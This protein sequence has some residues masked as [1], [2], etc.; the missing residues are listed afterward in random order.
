MKASSVI[1]YQL[2]LVCTDITNQASLRLSPAS[3]TIRGTRHPRTA[4]R[5]L[6]EKVKVAWGSQ[7][8]L[9]LRWAS[10]PVASRPVLD[11][12]GHWGFSGFH[13]SWGGRWYSDESL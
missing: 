1:T 3:P 7:L 13:R 12:A 2:L 11:S 5:S 8:C 9:A 6:S 10:V 4:Y